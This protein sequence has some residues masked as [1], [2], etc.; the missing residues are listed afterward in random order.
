MANVVVVIG[1][2]RIAHADFSPAGAS[3][4]F[5]VERQSRGNG[6]RERLADSAWVQLGV[7]IKGECQGGI[8]GGTGE[9]GYPV[10]LLGVDRGDRERIFEEKRVGHDCECD[11]W[12]VGLWTEIGFGG[13]RAEYRTV[14]IVGFEGS[15]G[16]IVR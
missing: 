11:R 5:A 1:E 3:I 6:K 14:V 8:V 7:H 12:L 4:L 16:W 2:G 15:N 13:R 9:T 10:V